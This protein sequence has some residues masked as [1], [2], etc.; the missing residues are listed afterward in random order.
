IIT[1]SRDFPSMGLTDQLYQILPPIVLIGAIFYFLMWRPQQQ[2]QKE[3]QT[4]I[5]NIRRGDTV[6]TAGGI[7]ARVVKAP[8]KDDPEVTLEIAPDTQIQVLKATLGDIRAKGQPADSKT[9]K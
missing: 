9:D 5:D 1:R 3:H 7:V 4:A 6:I 2:R 8:A